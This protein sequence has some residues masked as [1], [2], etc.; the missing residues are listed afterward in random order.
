MN[1][2]SN[3]PDFNKEVLIKLDNGLFVVGQY[4]YIEMNGFN[5]GYFT[6]GKG[7]TGNDPH[8]SGKPVAW[9]ELP[10]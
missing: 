10:Y 3:P 4:H 2:I 7:I 9:C 5:H 6:V 1:S 8:M